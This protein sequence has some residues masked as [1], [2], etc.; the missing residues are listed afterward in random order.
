[1]KL[2]R[3]LVCF[4]IVLCSFLQVSGQD[5]SNK[6]KEFWLAYPSHI[7]GTN[8]VM[9]LYITASVNTTGT[10]Q[11]AGGTPINFNVQANVV[12]RIFLN[13]TGTGTIT[14]TTP[15]YYASNTSVY[16]NNV[17][18][19][20]QANAAIKITAQD[21]VVV[22]AHIIR[23]AR[24]AATLALPTTVLGKEYI[25]PS[26]NSTSTQGSSG[27][28]T[29]GG[30]S[31]IVVVAT[32]PNTTVTITPT[33]NGRG[34]KPA[35]TAFTV[36]LP[37]AGDC[38]QFQSQNLGDLSGTKVS[39][40]AGSGGT[41]KPIAVFS[42]TTWSAFDCTGST[43]GDNL[44]QQLFPTQSWGKT[45]VTAPFYNRTDDIFRIYVQNSSTTVDVLENGTKITLGTGAFNSNGKFYTY[46]T[47]RPIVVTA[48]DPISVVQ[49]ITSASCKTGCATNTNTV[50]CYGDPEMVL[51][52]PVEQTL[53]D[54]TFF[55]AH[56]SF[57]PAGQTQI[58]THFVNVIVSKNFKSSVKIDN[59]APKGSFVDIPG[60]NYSYLQED[61][62]TSSA[63]NPIHRV[64]AD[65]GFSAIVYGYG[66]VES[67]GY[68]G[69]TNVKDFTPK[70]T[71]QNPYGRVDSAVTCVNSQ[72]KLSVPLSFTPS[73]MRWDF[74]AATNISPNATITPSSI[75]AD[76]TKT[77]NG[78]SVN[79]YSPGVSFTFSAIN[80]VSVR[81]TIK[82]YTTS[83][84][85]DG[86]GSTDQVYTIPI[87]VRSAPVAG[88]SFSH[89]GCVSDPLQLTDQSTGLNI[90]RWLWDFGDGGTADQTT[91]GVVRTYTSAGS[92]N[93]TVKLKVASDVGCVS[94]E[95]S[96]TV[97]VT[98][99]PSASFTTPSATCVN[100][101]ISFTDAS[102]IQTGS[103][104]K[105]T[106]NL[107]D[108]KG[109]F[110]N[111]SSAAP[112]ATYSS[113]GK[114]NVTLQV[115]SSTGCKSDV[116]SLSTFSINPLPQVGFIIPEVC[117]SDASAPFSDTSK[118]ADGSEAQF[119][120]LWNFNAGSPAVSPGPNT[121]SSTQ[122][123]PAVKY[124]KADNYK[125]SLRVTSKD[126][127]AATLTKDF[128]VNG[129][130]PNALFDVQSLSLLCSNDSVRIINRSSVDFGNV[131]RLDI[132]W[133]NA[134]APAVKVPDE[135]PFI[136][137]TYALRY[138]NFQTPATKAYTIRLVAFS[139]NSSA[140]SRSLS[141]PIVV[142]RSPK[143]SMTTLPGICN[144]AA[145]RQITQAS[146]DAQVPGVFAYS[147]NGVNATGLY[148]PQSVAAGTYPV[149]Y[150]YTSD[151]G[152]K[153]SA[154]R[155]ITVW[156]TPLAKWG[157][158]DPVCQKNDIVFTDSSDARFSKIIRR[159]WNF[160]DGT[161]AVTR[162]DA[163][164]FTRRFENSKV[165][166]ISLQVFTDSGC[167]STVNTQAIKVNYLPKPA[168]TLPNVCL[169]D[170]KAV[171][172]NQSSIGDG[173][174]ALFSYLWSFDDPNDPSAST[175]KEP[176]HR[177]TAL[178]P[179]NVSLKI[180]SK[181][182]CVDSLRQ[183]FNT[184]FP[185]PK[186]LFTAQPA[187]ACMGDSILFVDNGDGKTSKAASW[188][189]NLAQGFNSTLQNPSRRF[190]DSGNFNI[191]YYFFNAQ[192][193]VSDT[194]TSSITVHPYPKLTMGPSL[195]VLEGGIITIKP[196]Y[197]YGTNL[198][199][200]WTPPLYLNS[201]TTVNPKS[202][203]PDD[204]TY[205]LAV[206][207][208]GGCTVKDTIFIKVLK[209]PEVPNIFTPNGDGINDTWHIKYL[210]SYPN[211][212]IQ[213]FNRY[214][215]KVFVSTGYDTE[216]DG[217]YNGK[218]LPIGTYYYI[219]NPKNGRPIQK[220]SVTILK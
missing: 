75:T 118:I 2:I 168:F 63:T 33:A 142:N 148:T 170:G 64:V 57:V 24:S 147:G 112:A 113:T 203:P 72:M 133:D 79:Y 153:D 25:V 132:Y 219:I 43:G 42:A 18:D 202:T 37:N 200:K 22:Y 139:G 76:S 36:S 95:V 116:F 189:W 15:Q 179:Y 216:W 206:T 17:Q 123:N 157:V 111:T 31:E 32:Q 26:M 115:E 39:S 106:W 100:S 5:Y 159:V 89:A 3:L 125:V 4:G 122:K 196:V 51:L 10:V 20:V 102:T 21:P 126:G 53:N 188:V 217:T 152:C 34:G 52:N 23:S 211:A 193:C 131:T 220:G 82:L 48:S 84:T 136:G 128:T 191:T 56:A 19:A 207:G 59:A 172:A 155:N 141:V 199:Y 35:G 7:D 38:Y 145:A 46:R 6:G 41:C 62:T 198:Q 14:G 182:G 175:L 215:E 183:V 156:P 177:Y 213:V 149:K 166:T 87:T 105:W 212:D 161:A 119:S 154:I 70:A 44:F 103:I 186:A 110:T 151:V 98:T 45:F 47:N 71:I 134:N 162:T 86:C 60:T 129:S 66:N 158:S 176:M 69:G 210:E 180:T 143:V 173:S 192:G 117:L 135:D 137:K 13:A 165:N 104:A 9:G 124:N 101:S 120:Y 55:S 80:S 144:E 61:L 27:N 65:T 73:T 178:G 96:K 167:Q 130:N 12:T 160:D 214:G 90:S 78:V 181:D 194:V 88:F 185:Q 58:A 99:K 163:G 16:L 169:P 108:G 109:A 11:L 40:S 50:N 171:F 114:R 81:D 54:I 68:N 127:C 107:D 209:A 8:S 67:Y 28:G 187:E 85:P 197:I 208:I 204:I 97:P 74:S 164:T 93:Y 91:G 218:P 83:S 138:P 49:Y 146:F 201:D 30:V 1:M 205:T 29:I 190:S 92:G 174:E 121:T 140:C 94:A 150:L 195:K 184:V 77:V